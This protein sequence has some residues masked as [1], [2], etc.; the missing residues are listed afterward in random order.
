MAADEPGPPVTITLLPVNFGVIASLAADGES[1]C[2]WPDSTVVEPNRGFQGVLA[3]HFRPRHRSHER[4]GSAARLLLPEL[5]P[6]IP[7]GRAWKVSPVPGY[8]AV[9]IPVDVLG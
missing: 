9:L 3:A 4:L 2:L 7:T 6:C 5:R 1:A 8:T